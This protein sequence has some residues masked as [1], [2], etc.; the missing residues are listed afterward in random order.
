ML[1]LRVCFVQA[2]QREDNRPRRCCA[3]NCPQVADE[4]LEG[5]VEHSGRHQHEM[6]A[7]VEAGEVFRRV[8]AWL[9]DAPRVQ[10]RQQGRLGRWEVVFARKTGSTA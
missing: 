1:C 10:K 6:S 4:V 3:A 5:M 2:G 9:I 7:R 8:V